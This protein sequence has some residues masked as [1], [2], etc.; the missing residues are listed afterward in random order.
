MIGIECVVVRCGGE[1]MEV[2]TEVV[3][4]Y[5]CGGMFRAWV[6]EEGKAVCRVWREDQEVP[7]GYEREGKRWDL[8]DWYK[9]KS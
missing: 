9:E 8:S 2:R 1:V 4:D 7:D 5:N 6:D 3:Q